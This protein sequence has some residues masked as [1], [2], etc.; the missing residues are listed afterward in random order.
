MKK[1]IIR[2]GN[3]VDSNKSFLLS[4]FSATS[5]YTQRLSHCFYEP[6]LVREF[7]NSNEMKRSGILCSKIEKKELAL[8]YFLLEKSKS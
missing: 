4:K 8:G 3:L 1:M 2:T 5:R 6:A 7:D